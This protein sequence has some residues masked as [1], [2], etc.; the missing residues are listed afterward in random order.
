MLAVTSCLPV[1]PTGTGCCS[2]CGSQWQGRAPQQGQATALGQSPETRAEPE[3]AA[4]AGDNHP[5]PETWG[6]RDGGCPSRGLQAWGAPLGPACSPGTR[7]AAGAGRVRHPEGPARPAQVPSTDGHCVPGCRRPPRLRFPDAGR[8]RRPLLKSPFMPGEPDVPHRQGAAAAQSPLSRRR[9][10]GKGGPRSRP[11][12]GVGL[13]PTAW[14]GTAQHGTAR[15]GMAP[16]ILTGTGWE[17]H[18]RGTPSS[19]PRAPLNAT[20]RALGAHPQLP[21]TPIPMPGCPTLPTSSGVPGVRGGPRTHSTTLLR[22]RL[23]S[24]GWWR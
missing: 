18:V 15:P 23:F 24:L 11:H 14:R 4:A 2:R 8:G 13:Q 21:C 9:Q 6:R 5:A 22:Q 16:G 3:W 12:G 10:E 17:R 19:L 1:A 20:Q 7:G